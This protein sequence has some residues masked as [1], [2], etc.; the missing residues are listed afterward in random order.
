ML[1]VKLYGVGVVTEE[2]VISQDLR[3]GLQNSCFAKPAHVTLKKTLEATR[4]MANLAKKMGKRTKWANAR[5]DQIHSPVGPRF[6]PAIRHQPTLNLHRTQLNLGHALT[7]TA[8]CSD[9]A[10]RLA[11]E[12]CSL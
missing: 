3:D 4:E 9:T 6:L 2:T 5:D 1:A 11:T 8:S 12:C 10:R 7:G